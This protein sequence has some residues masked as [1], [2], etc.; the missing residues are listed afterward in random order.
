MSW[1]L[2]DF[3]GNP[4][5]RIS[6]PQLWD[7]MCEKRYIADVLKNQ[8]IQKEGL[9]ERAA[10]IEWGLFIVTEEGCSPHCYL[11]AFL[12]GL[13]YR[14][15]GTGWS[16]VG[17]AAIEKKIAG[18]RLVHARPQPASAAKLILSGQKNPA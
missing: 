15:G 4:N 10:E 1:K 7:D 6:N 9:A 2:V 5:S 8:L 17:G 11:D 13:A 16:C 12:D 14:N 18:R 3:T